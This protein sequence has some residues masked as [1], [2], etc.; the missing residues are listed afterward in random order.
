MKTWYGSYFQLNYAVSSA[1]NG[2]AL[3]RVSDK[4]DHE[5]GHGYA[6]LVI[7]GVSAGE[8]T[9]TVV[10]TDRAGLSVEHT[11]NIIAE[12]RPPRVTRRI[13]NR[14][15]SAGYRKV[16]MASKQPFCRSRRA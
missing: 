9:A 13:S 1:D 6:R 5:T 7:E 16:C 3:V 15:V 8:T 4:R 2:I 11:F 12:T 14:L 10:A